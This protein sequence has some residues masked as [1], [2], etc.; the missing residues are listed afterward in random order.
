M[1]SNEFD[2]RG[3]SDDEVRSYLLNECDFMEVRKLEDGAWIGLLKLAF[4][5]SVC[6][7]IGPITPFAYR[8]CFKDP[9]EARLFFSTAQAFDDIPAVRT[10][11]KG[12]RYISEPRIVEY[13]ELGL[14][15]W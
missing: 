8:W 15:K 12:H 14:P 2:Q 10:S 5:L 3:M 7:D 4:T 13:D 1:L 11:L 9:R 6:M